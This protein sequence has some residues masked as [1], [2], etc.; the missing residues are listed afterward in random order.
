MGE[1]KVKTRALEKEA[2]RKALKWCAGTDSKSETAGFVC[3]ARARSSRGVCEDLAPGHGN[4][5][6]EKARESGDHNRVCVQE[7]EI[8]GNLH[9]ACCTAANRSMLSLASLSL[10]LSSLFL[11]LS[12]SV[13]SKRRYMR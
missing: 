4:Q 9:H 2:L 1:K 3:I 6:V 7:R 5:I 10:S 13:Q 8:K 11:S 12:L